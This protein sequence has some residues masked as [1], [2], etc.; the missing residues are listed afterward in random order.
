MKK[1]LLPLL[2]NDYK[3]LFNYLIKSKN[4]VSEI[5]YFNFRFKKK[6]FLGKK[7]DV[8]RIPLDTIIAPYVLKNGSWDEYIINFVKKKT[9]D[10]NYIFLDIGAN[11]GLIS[12]QLINSNIKINQFLCFEPQEN[13][14]KLLKYNLKYYK[15]IYCYNFGLGT[16]N[17]KRKLY[18]NKL[19]FGDFSFIKKTSN[20]ESSRIIDAN[21]FLKKELPK[22]LPLIYK[23]DTQGMDE[24]I[25]LH[26]EGNILKR[27]EIL[28]LEISNHELLK[29]NKYKFLRILDNFKCF[30]IKGKAITK[31]EILN[32][33]NK[34]HE[35]DLMISK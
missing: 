17:I 2:K 27:I 12:R 19:N 8:L 22:R 15:N 32:K 18:K 23:S 33:I 26:L 20:Y 1:Y 14:Y 3:N 10:K 28:I 6:T 24:E 5:E 30:E 9:Q 31:I 13:N 16:K 35:F 7:G 4:K 25:L 34:E 11:I 29:K 21:Q